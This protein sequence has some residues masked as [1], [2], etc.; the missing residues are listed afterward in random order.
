MKITR[1]QMGKALAGAVAASA[2]AP[3]ATKAPAGPRRLVKIPNGWTTRPYQRDLWEYM[4]GGGWPPSLCHV[5]PPGRRIPLGHGLINWCCE[6][7]CPLYPRKQ[8]FGREPQ[9]VCL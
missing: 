5:A 7:R 8:T 1:R 6:W 9:N 3:L 4:A 2:V